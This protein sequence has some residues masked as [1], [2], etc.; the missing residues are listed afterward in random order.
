MKLLHLPVILVLLC[1]VMFIAPQHA[2]ATSGGCSSIGSHLSG[3]LNKGDRKSL[4]N[5]AFWK[6]DVVQIIVTLQDTKNGRATASVTDP[7][8]TYQFDTFPVVHYY[9][10]DQ[11]GNASFAVE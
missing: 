5:S 1:T 3:L 9:V 11:A 6:G 7:R 10:F 4:D 8:G 2:S